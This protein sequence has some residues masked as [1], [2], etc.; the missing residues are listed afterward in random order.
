MALNID[1]A[2][3]TFSMNRSDFTLISGTLY[4]ADTYFMWKQ[5]KA[6][7]ASEDGI[8]FPDA[9]KHGTEV[10]VAG[11]TFARTIELLAPYNGTFLPDEQWTARLSKSNNNFFDVENGIL[12]QNQVQ[13]ISTNSAGLIVGADGACGDYLQEYDILIVQE[14]LRHIVIDEVIARIVLDEDDVT[15]ARDK[16]LSVVLDET[17]ITV[18]VSC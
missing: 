10:T 8:V 18:R 6:W 16:E 13:V 17:T 3:F 11:T 2:T 5:I 4:D 14:E 9:Q 1:Y 7:E 12:N 15:I